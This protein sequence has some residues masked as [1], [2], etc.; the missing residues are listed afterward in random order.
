MKVCQNCKDKERCADL[1]GICLKLP[2]ILA[3]SIAVMVVVLMFN[4][5]L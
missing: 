3:A 4:S 1:P 2:C 5:T